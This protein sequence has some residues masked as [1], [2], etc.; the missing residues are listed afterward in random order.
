MRSEKSDDPRGHTPRSDGTLT[1]LAPPAPLGAAPPSYFQPVVR[2]GSTTVALPEGARSH[3]PGGGPQPPAPVAAGCLSPSFLAP[4][5]YGNRTPDQLSVTEIPLMNQGGVPHLHAHQRVPSQATNS[6]MIHVGVGG[7]GGGPG[8]EDSYSTNGGGGGFVTSTSPYFPPHQSHSGLSVMQ[9]ERRVMELQLQ[10]QHAKKTHKRSA[11]QISTVS[12]SG[13]PPPQPIATPP[14]FGSHIVAPPPPTTAP[15]PAPLSDGS[16][17]GSVRSALPHIRHGSYADGG[18]LGGS[19][20]M[21]SPRLLHSTAIRDRDT[22]IAYLEKLLRQRDPSFREQGSS[23]QHQRESS[24]SLEAASLSMVGDESVD[25]NDD[26]D[27]DNASDCPSF[28]EKMVAVE[29]ATQTDDVVVMLPQQAAIAKRSVET[30]CEEWLAAL[31]AKEALPTTLTPPTTTPPAMDSDSNGSSKTGLDEEQ[32][33]NEDASSAVPPPP[34]TLQPV[35]QM[36]QLFIQCGFL[37]TRPLNVTLTPQVTDPSSFLVAANLPPSVA[38]V[39]GG[40]APYGSNSGSSAAPHAAGS[41]GGS[42]ASAAR[43]HQHTMSGTST[44][45]TVVQNQPYQQQG[46]QLSLQ[47]QQHQRTTSSGHSRSNNLSF[48]GGGS[49]SSTV[50]VQ[51]TSTSMTKTFAAATAAALPSHQRTHSR[52]ATN[53]NEVETATGSAA[54][55]MTARA[56]TAVG[57]GAAPPG[58]QRQGSLASATDVASPRPS[59]STTSFTHKPYAQSPNASNSFLS[60]G[61]TSSTP[62]Q[63][64]SATVAGRSPPPP[65]LPQQVTTTPTTSL[66]HHRRQSSVGF[67]GNSLTS[68]SSPLMLETLPSGSQWADDFDDDDGEPVVFGGGSAVKNPPLLFGG[69]RSTTETPKNVSTGNRSATL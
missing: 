18:S 2:V 68:Q 53:S 10:L 13:P 51:L 54:T 38:S 67:G 25:P 65:P 63:Q 43:H 16:N 33:D 5:S 56:A 48:Q 28:V 6:P 49:S 61:I 22:R 40:G 35:E 64:Q 3:T 45:S 36:Q 44:S 15:P 59:G 55:T 20:V 9:L 12:N 29:M 7:S 66:S 17:R 32:E 47:Q 8:S 37:M 60:R 31:P 21:M 69:S 30:Q 52:N 1:P 19:L 23:S 57:T 39:A 50:A 26:D 34:R 24:I 62:T 4:P 58:H 41:K 11:S 14:P 27:E 42:S 46:K